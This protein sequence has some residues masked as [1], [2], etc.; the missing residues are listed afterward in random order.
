MK[1]RKQILAV[2]K[3]KGQYG[4]KN[5]LSVSAGYGMEALD[6]IMEGRPRPKPVSWSVNRGHRIDG[7]WIPVPIDTFDSPEEAVDAYLKLRRK[8]G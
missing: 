7:Q 3:S 4:K 8:E 5:R 6:A 1:S 2:L